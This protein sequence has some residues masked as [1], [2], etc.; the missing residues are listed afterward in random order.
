[1]SGPHPC[2]GFH[3]YLMDTLDKDI[4]I[5]IR[6]QLTPPTATPSHPWGQHENI[7]PWSRGWLTRCGLRPANWIRT[8][9][10]LQNSVLWL[11]QGSGT[12]W[13]VR[14]SLRPGMPWLSRQSHRLPACYAW[15]EICLETFEIQPVVSS[16]LVWHFHPG[17]F[18]VF[19]LR[20]RQ[21]CTGN[22]RNSPPLIRVIIRILRY[23]QASLQ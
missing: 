2:R 13:A 22:R 4:K 17:D 9:L 23:L 7:Y 15:Q 18:P 6:I 3:S 19:G 12:V 10:S 16:P 21:R 11:D 1:M 20:A 14:L 5:L 8:C